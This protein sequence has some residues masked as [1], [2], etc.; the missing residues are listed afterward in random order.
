MKKYNIAIVGA[1][2]NIG[3]EV[4]KILKERSFPVNHIVALAS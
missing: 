3:R 4:F 1:T 2:G